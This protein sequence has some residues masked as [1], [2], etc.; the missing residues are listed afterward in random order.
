M[1]NGYKRNGTTRI[2]VAIR[3]RALRICSKKE[4]AEQALIFM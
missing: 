2:N 4:R 3:L 1:G